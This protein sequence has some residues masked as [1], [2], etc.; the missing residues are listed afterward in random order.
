MWYVYK[1]VAQILKILKAEIKHILIWLTDTGKLQHRV[2]YFS[3]I[4][5]RINLRYIQNIAFRIT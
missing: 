2:R 5:I 1:N 3:Y 4:L